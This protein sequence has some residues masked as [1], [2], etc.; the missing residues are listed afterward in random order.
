[1]NLLDKCW[2]LLEEP[3]SLCRWALWNLNLLVRVYYLMMMVDV[4]SWILL[5]SARWFEEK[6]L[7]IS[8]F[9]Q[10]SQFFCQDSQVMVAFTISFC[11]IGH[12]I[13]EHF[14]VVAK[15]ELFGHGYNLE[16]YI[17]TLFSI[18]LPDV[19][20]ILVC[21]S[22]GHFCGYPFQWSKD[23]KCWPEGSSSSIYISLG[24]VQGLFG[25]FWG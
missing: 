18:F 2:L 14:L 7:W 13:L 19:H 11:I 1:M 9:C 15:F 24:T 22:P 8:F 4:V 17:C 3:E 5:M 10:V 21:C 12:Y 23:S 6:C 16:I 20:T 25:S